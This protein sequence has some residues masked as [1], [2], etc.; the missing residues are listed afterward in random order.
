MQCSHFHQRGSLALAAVCQVLQYDVES[1]VRRTGGL[2]SEDA[3]LLTTSDRLRIIMCDI[4]M[5]QREI[6]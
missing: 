2:R 6:V 5:L 3:Q 4:R 1:R